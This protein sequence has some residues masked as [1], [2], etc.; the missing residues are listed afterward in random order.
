LLGDAAAK[1]VAT[2]SSS[3]HSYLD[4]GEVEYPIGSV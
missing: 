2:I 4:Q 3:P 1:L